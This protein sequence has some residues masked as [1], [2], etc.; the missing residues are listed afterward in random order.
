MA[1][2]RTIKA[3][4]WSDVKIGELKRDARLLYIGMWNFADDCGVVSSDSRFL[5]ANIFP[6]DDIKPKE[7]D[8]WLKSLESSGMIAPIKYNGEDY[9]AVVNFGR[10]QVICRPNR[11]ALNIPQDVVKELV[12]EYK[13]R[14]AIEGVGVCI[15]EPDKL[16]EQEVIEPEEVKDI[17]DLAYEKFLKWQDSHA[18][19]VKKMKHPISKDD[20][21]KLRNKYDADMIADYLERMNNWAPLRK[22]CTSAYK[23]LINWIKRDE[24]SGNQAKD[25]SNSSRPG[26]TSVSADYAASIH[27]RMVGRQSDV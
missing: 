1:R 27:A 19:E 15:S 12:A 8:D 5:K 10:H 4:F 18:P 2:N 23:T 25:G 13:E 14:S 22:R 3:S 21:I 9:Y 20:F 17:N 16:V 11:K 26:N 24:K 6:F 7:I